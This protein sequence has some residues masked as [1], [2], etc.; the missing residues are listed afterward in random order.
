MTA[1]LVALALLSLL[2]PAPAAR[3]R[4]PSGLAAGRPNPVAAPTGH[5]QR[6]AE[7][8]RPSGSAAQ[9]QGSVQQPGMDEEDLDV[10]PL[11]GGTITQDITGADPFADPPT[12]AATPTVTT[13]LGGAPPASPVPPPTPDPY[14]ES[15]EE[16]SERVMDECV[17][18]E[19]WHNN[20]TNISAQLEWQY[21][22]AE[23]DLTYQG[24]DGMML[25][26]R[27]KGYRCAAYVYHGLCVN[28]HWIDDSQPNIP[29]VIEDVMMGEAYKFPENNCCACG[30]NRPLYEDR[31]CSHRA[32][33]F[34]WT[35][36][37]KL[38]KKLREAFVGTSSE[39]ADQLDTS[40]FM[41]DPPAWLEE[42]ESAMRGRAGL[43]AL[44]L[45]ALLRA[46]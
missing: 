7:P 46:A 20:Y 6:A 28:P 40:G 32:K 24:Y 34:V 11:E 30:K 4:A 16:H 41:V 18:T 36:E 22:M 19:D 43:A 25:F 27:H 13:T 12:P 15:V 1:P 42:V 38:Q 2:P 10:V 8:A 45:V 9:L 21:V 3:V 26:D 31:T 23:A 5:L 14:G 33:T 35:N 29:C 39:R 37:N 44:A 17:D